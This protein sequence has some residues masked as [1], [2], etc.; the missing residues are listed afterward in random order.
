MAT[1]YSID[2]PLVK[3]RCYPYSVMC[4]CCQ[5]L[6][7]DIRGSISGTDLGSL[8][9]YRTPQSGDD[10]SSNNARAKTGLYS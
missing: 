2:V 5:V 4:G 8:A 7:P 10:L 3:K 1:R 6:V 9:R